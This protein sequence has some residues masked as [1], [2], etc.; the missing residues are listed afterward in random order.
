MDTRLTLSWSDCL[1]EVG[2]P[3][4]HQFFPDVTQ[5]WPGPLKI[6]ND[7]LVDREVP[8]RTC[9][10]SGLI[11]GTGWA[12]VPAA[13]Q[14]DREVQ[15]E[16]SLYDRWDNVMRFEF[17]ARLDRHIARTS[18]VRRASL[19]RNASTASK[20]AGLFEPAKYPQTASIL[21]RNVAGADRPKVQS[22]P[23]RAT[24]CE[25]QTHF[26]D[27]DTSTMKQVTR[28]QRLQ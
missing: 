11:V 2:D 25:S 26:V 16:L 6:L 18:M 14:A 13:Y 9:Q 23:S 20:S 4:N 10:R 5:D 24:T 19:L 27:T 21:H 15:I 28:K 22:V 7:W 12:P 17:Q 1:L 8:L 3:R